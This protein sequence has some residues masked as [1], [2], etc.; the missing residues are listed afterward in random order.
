MAQVAHCRNSGH[1]GAAL[2]RVQMPLEFL[3]GLSR[4][5][6]FDPEA[7]RLVRRFQ[8][9]RGLLGKDCGDL[10]VVIGLHVFGFGNDRLRP[11]FRYFFL[12]HLSNRSIGLQGIRQPGDVLDKRCIVGPLLVGF[13]D[14]ADYR[15]DRFR[16]RLQGVDT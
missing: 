10:L 16:G 3:H 13:I 14:I 1:P 2:E 12:R 4:I 15:R 11:G 8:E 9:F 7:E 5:L 6:V